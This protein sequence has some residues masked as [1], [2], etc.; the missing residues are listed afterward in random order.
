MTKAKKKTFKP[1]QGVTGGA[2]F[3]ERLKF[4]R[5]NLVKIAEEKKELKERVSAARAALEKLAEELK[6]KKQAKGL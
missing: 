6:K 3:S 4:E 1:L 5:G 2:K